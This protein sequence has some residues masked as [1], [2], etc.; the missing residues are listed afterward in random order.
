MA[1]TDTQGTVLRRNGVAIASVRSIGEI[2]IGRALRDV[3][4]L[5]DSVHKHKLNIPDIPEIP[6]EIF[7]DPDLGIHNQLG[8]DEINGTQATWIV[9]I[10]QGAS[11]ESHIELGACWLFSS[12]TGPYEVDGDIVLKVTLKPQS[13]PVGLFD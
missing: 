5:S 7:Y 3:T 4:A 9:D 8:Q 10:E 6:I 1:V 11:P 13:V 2:G 12:A